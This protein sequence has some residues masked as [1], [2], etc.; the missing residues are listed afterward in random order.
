V[1]KY[2]H[3]CCLSLEGEKITASSCS[4]SK[5]WDAS[6]AFLIMSQLFFSIVKNSPID[7]KIQ[8]R[9][10]NEGRHGA[11]FIPVVQTLEK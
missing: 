5:V 8:K 10:V 6:A 2:P 1:W 11:V 3:N 7:Q 4:I 9:V